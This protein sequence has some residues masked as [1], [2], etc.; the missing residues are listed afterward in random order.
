MKNICPSCKSV[1]ATYKFGKLFECNVCHNH[2]YGTPPEH[3]ERALTVEEEKFAERIKERKER[4]MKEEVVV[5][6]EESFKDE[7]IRLANE[8]RQAEQVPEDAS[9]KP[10]KSPGRPRK[11]E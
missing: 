3:K 2:F 7:I 4:A 10:M 11:S 5:V 8:A 9:F 1:D 6:E